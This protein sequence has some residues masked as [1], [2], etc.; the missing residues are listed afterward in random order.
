MGAPPS[1]AAV[2][3]RIPYRARRTLPSAEVRAVGPGVGTHATN[4][5]HQ[6]AEND[7]ED[8]LRPH[9]WGGL[10]DIETD[11]EPS[12]AGEEA[13]GLLE[14]WIGDNGNKGE[15]CWETYSTCE[16]IAN[17]LTWLSLVPKA[18]RDAHAPA[19]IEIFLA[20][21]GAWI[22]ERLEF[23]G[24]RLT[25]NH[26][27]NNARALVMV[28]AALDRRDFVWSGLGVFD[29]MLAR[30]VGPGGA[31]CERSSHYQLVVMNWIL[32]AVFFLRAINGPYAAGADRL[33]E[34]AARMAA[35]GAP[36][37]DPQGRL[38][39]LIGDISPDA[40]P[41]ATCRRLAW[42]Y[43]DRWPA[44]GSIA[45]RGRCDDWY[46]L[47]D[48]G[49]RLIVNFPV[50]DFPTPWRTHGHSDYTGFVLIHRGRE[51]LRDSGQWRYAKDAISKAQRSAEGH[52]VPIVDGLGPTC[53]YLAKGEWFPT[54]Y[55]RASVRAGFV[56]RSALRL[57]HSG[58]RRGGKVTWHRRELTLLDGT[59]SVRD[60]FEGC[61]AAE[62]QLLW[63]LAPELAPTTSALSRFEGGG[64]SLTI[65]DAPTDCPT[66]RK[67]V[68]GQPGGG[69][70]STSYGEV[71]PAPMLRVVRQVQ[72]PFET[73]TI[74]SV[75][76]CVG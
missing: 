72:L 53:E 5:V 7:P 63:Q 49:L 18:T 56:D 38:L 11:G 58:F 23:H 20:D 70:S 51:L 9:R 12:P 39:T 1:R 28:G 17:L 40:T 14:R 34:T 15:A 59:L 61:E 8:E 10:I 26:I 22:L 69:W 47:D 30:L 46:W 54:P 41:R 36:A 50:G 19:G 35:C 48:G 62:I 65:T 43:P 24:D 71:A 55:A 27:L 64:V 29:K 52:S 6:S 57:E 68:C 45:S 75:R 21:S 44:R 2:L 60:R 25:N 76:S 4:P 13:R 37:C 16:R 42:L 74:F 67:L 33:E 31:L 3:E 66:E 73:E 32:D